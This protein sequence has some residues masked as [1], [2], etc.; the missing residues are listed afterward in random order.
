[1]PPRDGAP[2]KQRQGLR[3]AVKAIFRNPKTHTG[4]GP[5]HD[6]PWGNTAQKPDILPTIHEAV[7]DHDTAVVDKVLGAFPHELY[8]TDDQGMTPMALAILHGNLTMAKHLSAANASPL[9]IHNNGESLMC[10]AVIAQSPSLVRWL[11]SLYPHNPTDTHLLLN[12]RDPAGYTPLHHAVLRNST[13][14]ALA[15]LESGADPDQQQQILSGPAKEEETNPHLPEKEEEEEKEE[16]AG[17]GTPLWHVLNNSNKVP[18]STQPHSTRLAM[19]RLLLQH[20]GAAAAALNIPSGTEGTFPLHEAVM[21]AAAASDDDENGTGEEAIGMLLDVSGKG[22]IDVG[23]TV[24]RDRDMRGSTPLMYAAAMC[25]V[26]VVRLLLARGADVGRVN[27]VGET[28]LHWAGVNRTS[29]LKKNDGE[30]EEGGDTEGGVEVIRLLVEEQGVDVNGR[31]RLGATALHGAAYCGLMGN[32]K[33]LLQL[34]A[35]TRLVAED[36]HYEKLVGLRGTAE[37]LAR[38]QGHWEVAEFIKEREAARK[39]RREGGRGKGEGE[40]GEGGKPQGS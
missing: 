37:E 33:Q 3:S 1:M 12:A 20:G 5:A 21:G 8:L 25:R 14:V 16:K 23:T 35:D 19:I 11:A 28:V 10:F 29:S 40:T 9:P 36:F 27:A 2:K 34:G 15:L 30:G 32:V 22:D 38:A 17:A 18:P 7:R 31:N 24:P 6:S 4:A 39:G 13:D 26:R